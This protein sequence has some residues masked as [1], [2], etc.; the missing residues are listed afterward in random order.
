MIFYP[1]VCY[2]YVLYTAFDDTGESVSVF[3][4]KFL[5]AL[6]HYGHSG[7]FY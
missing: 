3:V 4:V 5:Y 1:F 2:W 6:K 7:R